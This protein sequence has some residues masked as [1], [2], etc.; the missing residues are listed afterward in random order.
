V[1]S[2]FIVGD[3]Q[4]IALLERAQNEIH[5]R[6][7]RLLDVEVLDG[8]C[9]RV[10]HGPL[11]CGELLLGKLRSQHV[12]NGRARAAQDLAGAAAWQRIQRTPELDKR[13]TKRGL[14]LRNRQLQLLRFGEL[15][16]CGL[17]LVPSLLEIELARV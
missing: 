9:L 17:E 2:L 11:D 13:G 14:E 4:V 12:E 1:G 10:R 16:L 6:L 7:Q 3:L 5:F 8:C 15:E